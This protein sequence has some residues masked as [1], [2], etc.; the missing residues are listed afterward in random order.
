MKTRFWKRIKKP[1]SEIT[2]T[3]RKI[4]II[5]NRHGLLFALVLLLMLAG[6]MNYNNSMGFLLTFLLG[7]IMIVSTLHTYYNLHLLKIRFHNAP[8]V[9]AGQT[10]YIQLQVDNAQ[11]KRRYAIRVDDYH[12]A[13]SDYCDVAA[14]SQALLQLP[15]ITKRRGKYKLPEKISIHTEFPLNIFYAWYPMRLQGEFWVYPK[16]QG[17]QPLLEQQGL[18]GDKQSL[19]KRSGDDFVGYRDYHPAESPKHVDWKIVA[20]NQGWH[21]KQFGG[22]ACEKKLWL[23]WQDLQTQSTEARLSQLCQWIL[24]AE[25]QGLKYGLDL[26]QQQIPPDNGISHQQRCL[27]ALAQF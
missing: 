7:S 16:P 4:Y 9:F 17:E 23:R 18:A 6:A 1:D 27:L 10:A 21:I 20:R 26:P 19:H 14:N 12:G 3:R 11:N 5:P 13:H 24:T 25:Q 2:L 22:E 8:A 15:C